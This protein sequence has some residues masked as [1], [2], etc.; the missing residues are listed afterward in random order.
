ME[1]SAF[2]ENLIWRTDARS[3]SRAGLS[4]PTA[5]TDGD[6]VG[7]AAPRVNKEGSGGGAVYFRYDTIRGGAREELLQEAK[8]QSTASPPL[9]VR[10]STLIPICRSD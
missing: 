6:P 9:F 3:H 10:G 4:R 2:R 1:V 5:L 7:P 8:S